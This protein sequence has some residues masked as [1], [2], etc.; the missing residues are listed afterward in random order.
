MRSNSRLSFSGIRTALT[1]LILSSFCVSAAA[2][3][4]AADSVRSLVRSDE[5]LAAGVDRAYEAPERSFS[6]APNGWE[7]FYVSHYGRHGS[8]YAHAPWIYTDFLKLLKAAKAEDNLTYEGEE[9]L[10]KLDSFYTFVGKYHW[11]DLS[12]KGWEQQQGIARRMVSSAGKSAFGKGSRIDAVASNSARSMMSMSAFCLAASR[13]APFAIVYEH[14]GIAE[15]RSTAPDK[16]Q[17][18]D[19]LTGTPTPCPWEWSDADVFYALFPDWKEVLGRYLKSPDK[20]VFCIRKEGKSERESLAELFCNTYLLDE[21]RWSY[22]A[23]WPLPRIF[24]AEETARL[25]EV[26]NYQAFRQWTAVQAS[27][28]QVWLD[29]ISKADERIATGEKGADLRFGHDHVIIA[30]M[31]AADVDGFG[32]IP[33]DARDLP[34]VF[35]TYKI[36]MAANLQLL[37]FKPKSAKTPSAHPVRVRLL[38]NEVPV[39]LGT[40]VPDSELCYSW[41]EVKDYLLQCARKLG[42]ERYLEDLSHV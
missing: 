5:R 10:E 25:W 8:R 4:T 39:T 9:M 22:A 32:D 37:F 38:L 29:I 33:S 2:Q 28:F 12:E 30:M 11:G 34:A 15:L 27:C 24:T 41:T 20:S 21:G 26:L 17:N 19:I 31:L 7:T 3:D 1:A 35:Q 42:L 40:L 14:Q 18:P 16:K 23:Q 36:P 13:E 6:T